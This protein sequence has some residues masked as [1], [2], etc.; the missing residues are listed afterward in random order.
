MSG[1]LLM[2]A[3]LPHPPI[4]IP[5]IGKDEVLKVKNTFDSL[6][7]LSKD[8]VEA[9]PDTI[10]IVTPHSILNPYYFSVYYDIEL[11]AGFSNF[12]APNT[13]FSF[14]NDIE[15]VD[16]LECNIRD[17]FKRLNKLPDNILLDHGSGVPLYFLNKAGYKGKIAVINYTALSSENH[18]LFG[19]L[20]AKT[21]AQTDKKY[22]FIASGDLC[23]RLAPNAPAGFNPQGKNFDELICNSIQNG[24]YDAII[25]MPSALREEAA[26]CAYNSLMT[27]FGVLN[28]KPLNNRILSYEAP[29]GVGYLVATL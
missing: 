24:D 12:G 15:F 8:V 3:L 29:F 13:Q 4:V 22:V 20:I 16:K 10:I 5:E 11:N 18:I 27:A 26:E 14:N 17:S 19:S 21:L 6:E 9:N 28:K 25:N 7:K 23:H 2:A 1:N